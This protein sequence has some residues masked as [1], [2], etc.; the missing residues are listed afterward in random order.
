MKIIK[1]HYDAYLGIFLGLPFQI[2]KV[3]SFF[4]LS[5]FVAGV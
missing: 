5:V 2:K 1:T 4:A 3:N